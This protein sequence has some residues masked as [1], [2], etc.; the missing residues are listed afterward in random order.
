M[1]EQRSLTASYNSDVDWTISINAV[2]STQDKILKPHTKWRKKEE[3]KFTGKIEKNQKIRT[4]T[5]HTTTYSSND[6]SNSKSDSLRSDSDGTNSTINHNCRSLDLY[7]S[8]SENNDDEPNQ[9]CKKRH[10]LSKPRSKKQR[11]SANYNTSSG[12][13]FPSYVKDNG[14]DLTEI[15]IRFF[16]SIAKLTKVLMKSTST[17]RASKS[18]IGYLS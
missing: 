14:L 17:E 18:M 8:V 16:Q 9:Y 12:N 6:N 3:N 7:S 10:R 15:T 4:Q 13:L 1:R 2:L 5:I 11:Q